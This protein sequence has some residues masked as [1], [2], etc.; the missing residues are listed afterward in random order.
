MDRIA[1]VDNL[2]SEL[3]QLSVDNQHD[4]GTSTSA[5]SSKS[6]RG[7]DAAV[8]EDGLQSGQPFVMG[9]ADMAGEV[10]RCACVCILYCCFAG[11]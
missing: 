3:E 7:D 6:L 10:L 4:D 9:L 11:L 5:V 8:V 2:A 1:A